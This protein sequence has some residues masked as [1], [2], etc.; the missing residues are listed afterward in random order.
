MSLFQAI[1]IIITLVALLGYLNYRLLRLPEPVGI[2]AAGFALSLLVAGAGIVHPPIA[3][4][5][6]DMLS[7]IDFTGLMF[8]GMLGLLLFAGSLQVSWTD[9][10]KQRWTIG[11]LATVGVAV[12]TLAVGAGLYFAFAW[13]GF[14]LPFMWCL[15][16]GALIS[17]TD[18]IAVMVLFRSLSVPS[19]L[20]HKI[21]GE[22]LFNDATAVVCFVTLVGIAT[23]GETTTVAQFAMFFGLQ[24][25]AGVTVGMLVGS[26]AI[27]LI[28]G[29]DSYPV[30]ILITLAMPTA[31]Y[32]LA[33][34]MHG[35]GPIAVVL[36]G[37]IIGNQ[38]RAHVMSARTRVE[39]FSF[40]ALMDELLNLIL[41][42]LI[43]LQVIA[44]AP[45]LAKVQPALV[46]IPIV[47]A[48]RFI[49]VG[50]PLALMPGLMRASPHMV[51][52]MTWAGLRGGI[53]VALAL[54]LPAGSARDPII[55]ATYG[56]VMF[57]IL[58]QA[59]TLG[60]VLRRWGLAQRATSGAAE[61]PLRRP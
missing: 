21:T 38:G 30:E 1:G 28:R 17:P 33:E 45:S 35:S 24:V 39:L 20:E 52:V 42:A 23:A 49:S 5:A 34:V 27:V 47:L 54:S 57:S 60:P 59:L 48:G 53:S 14:A 12:S 25:L 37:L 41:F 58:V 11:I 16:F 51:K 8:H 40:W 2:T 29:I 15:V 7:N 31:G 55:S 43:G 6:A 61:L 50:L 32:A 56:V 22:S 46:A 18:P 13:L 26:A 44:L 10:G 9:L 3:H 4:A 36:M 19:D